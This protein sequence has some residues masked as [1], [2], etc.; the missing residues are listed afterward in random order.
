[1]RTV[2]LVV[3]GSVLG[4]LLGLAILLTP[5]LPTQA[6]EQADRFNNLWAYLILVTG[7]LFGIVTAVL[8]YSI[9][10]FRGRRG[11]LD[12]GPPIHG[13]TWLEITWTAVPFAIVIS[14]I[15]FSWVILN[16]N[17]PSSAFASSN[18][19]DPNTEQGSGRLDVEVLG[20]QY[21]WKYTLPQYGVR[22][23]DVLVVPD[24]RDIRF[25]IRGRDVI[26]SFWVPDWRIQMFSVPGRINTVYATPTKRGTY[27]VICSFLC[28][29]GHWSMNS[30]VQGGL[31][32]PIRVVSSGQFQGWVQKQRAAG[33]KQQSSSGSSS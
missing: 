15:I 8:V 18:Q 2:V 19:D 10:T 26:H 9:R 1:M 27:R 7:V 28:G 13:I 32:Q 25:L 29:A 16:Q 6:S 33:Q 14:I 20:Y 24:H 23:Q 11:D 3:V 4:G 31:A 12:D 30:E 22:D 5:F 21:G 17:Q